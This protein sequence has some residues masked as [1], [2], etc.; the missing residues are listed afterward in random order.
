MKQSILFSII[1]PTL[2]AELCISRTLKAV[3]DLGK[4]RERSEIIIVDN[5][6]FDR[7]LEI[8]RRFSIK[9][10]SFPGVNVSALRNRGAKHAKGEILAFL[11]ADCIVPKNW[12][13]FVLPYFD[14]PQTGA[15]GSISFHLPQKSTWVAKTWFL[16]LRETYGEADYL[17]SQN[18]F[19]S[20]RVFEEIGGFD[21]SLISNEDC[22]LCYRLKQGGYKVV[23]DPRLA[24]THLGTPQTLSQFFK[25]EVWHGKSVFWIFLRDFPKLKNLKAVSYGLFYVFSF[26]AIPISLISYLTGGESSPLIF[27]TGLF[28]FA[29]LSL[30]LKTMAR[31]RKVKYLLRLTVVY[32]TY[33]LARAISIFDL[34]NWLPLIKRKPSKPNYQ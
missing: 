24:V 32:L 8:A 11:D 31:T 29:P 26:I 2:N 27:L 3:D 34:Q 5:G 10:L 33:G 28:L 19:I 23:S 16:N 21:E 30:A 6:S 7:T 12:L 20:K 9:I 13:E 25:R 15:V 22:D 17:V 14:D 18:L 1:I 4:E